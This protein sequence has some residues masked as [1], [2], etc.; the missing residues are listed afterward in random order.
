[1]V[2]KRKE[3]PKNR[4]Y[5]LRGETAGRT[6]G[7]PLLTDEQVLECRLLHEYEGW[8]NS[9][10]AEAFGVSSEYMRSILEYRTRCKLIPRKR[11]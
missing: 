10:L 8:K 5:R 11:K 4:G 9:A 1:M 3:D 2:S 7:V 6:G